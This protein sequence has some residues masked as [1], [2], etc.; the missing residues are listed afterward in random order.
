MLLF[1]TFVVLIIVVLL[2][3]IGKVIVAT[4]LLQNTDLGEKSR[5]L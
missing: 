4:V 2:T 1:E 3:E 5:T